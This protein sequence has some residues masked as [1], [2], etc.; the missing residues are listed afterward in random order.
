MPKIVIEC[1]GC[2]N[3]L[4]IIYN[5][6]ETDSKVQDEYNAHMAYLMFHHLK[7]HPKGDMH[8]STGVDPTKINVDTSKINPQDLRKVKENWVKVIKPAP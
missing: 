3:S 4:T 8:G 1:Q 6:D 7:E 5:F 2:K